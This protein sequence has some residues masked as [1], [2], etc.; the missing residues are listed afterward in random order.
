MYT[1]AFGRIVHKRAKNR[2]SISFFMNNFRSFLK[3]YCISVNIWVVN[4]DQEREDP[5]QLGN[6]STKEHAL[7]KWALGGEPIR[8]QAT[9]VLSRQLLA[10]HFAKHSPTL[11]KTFIVVP[12]K[13]VCV[14]L[15][16]NLSVFAKA[17]LE[18]S[19]L[20]QY[21]AV[22]WKERERKSFFYTCTDDIPS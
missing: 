4:Y 10:K 1:V 3:F 7:A 6:Y 15:S 19:H 18:C 9:L 13:D 8:N 14:Y 11:R 22:E 17:L 16:L 20:Q 12:A 5:I 2:V 21:S